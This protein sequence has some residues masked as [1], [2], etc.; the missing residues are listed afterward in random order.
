MGKRVEVIP[1]ILYLRC[2]S[3]CFTA[4]G[5]RTKVKTFKTLNRDWT[6][7]SWIPGRI[8]TAEPPGKL[9]FVYWYVRKYSVS[10]KGKTQGNKFL[11]WIK[12]SPSIHSVKGKSR[13]GGERP[14]LGG[15]QEKYNQQGWDCVKE[16]A[17][18]VDKGC[19][20]HQ[21]LWPCPA[22]HPEGIQDEGKQNTRHVQ[23]W[24]INKAECWRTDAFKFWHLGR[25]LRVPWMASRSK[26][27]SLKEISAEYS[28]EGLMLKMK[29]QY[30]GHLIWRAYLLENTLMLG[31]TE[32]RRRRGQ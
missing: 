21:P 20:S 16:S 31:K 15:D 17:W 27:T 22:V 5:D 29:L 1:C 12:P 13:S 19:W 28:L 4:G 8:F 2:S 23:S 32:G 26:Q 6:C 24:T 11:K 10:H 30:F 7:I 3:Q 9:P 25:H 14:A 18:S